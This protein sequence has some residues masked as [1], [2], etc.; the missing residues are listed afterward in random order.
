MS[1]KQRS[2]RKDRTT[3]LPAALVSEL[4][5]IDAEKDSRLKLRFNHS[6]LTRKAE[7]KQKRDEKK[8]RKAAFATH[9]SQ[10]KSPTVLPK[11]PGVGPVGNKG[12]KRKLE[13]ASPEKSS[14]VK[15]TKLASG[16]KEPRS[17]SDTGKARSTKNDKGTSNIP[18]TKNK[19]Q[20]ETVEADKR[21]LNKLAETNP[22]FVRMLRQSNLISPDML[23]QRAGGGDAFTTA[24]EDEQEIRK[25]SR[26]LGIKSE[27]QMD[28][29]LKG[30]GLGDIVQISSSTT[31]EDQKKMSKA[32]SPSDDEYAEEQIEGFGDDDDFG[33]GVDDGDEDEFD[34]VEEDDI[35]SEGDGVSHSDDNEQDD[36][37]AMES[38]EFNKNGSESVGDEDHDDGGD[39][40][41]EVTGTQSSDTPALSGKYVPPHLRKQHKSEPTIPVSS[42]ISAAAAKIAMMDDSKRKADPSY[43]RLKRQMQGLM[44]RLSDTNIENIFGNLEEIYRSNRRKDVTEIFTELILSYIGDH[45]NLLDSFVLTYAAL[46]A[47]VHNVLGLE[48][49]ASFVQEMIE[50][51]ERSRSE[52]DQSSA[53]ELP[54]KR[55]TN[56]ASLLARL[57]NFK[58]V[59]CVL[60]YD[61][62]REALSRL[63]EIDIEMLLRILR[64]CGPE[65][66]HDDPSALREI[67][68]L[69]QSEVAKRDPKLLSARC[70][71]MI[72]TINDLKNNHRQKKGAGASGK[73]NELQAEKLGKF[74]NGIVSRR[75]G[76]SEALR[77][78][79]KD[80]RSVDTKGRWWLVGAAWAGR[81][82]DDD[83]AGNN[84]NKVKKWTTEI[85]KG[86]SGDLVSLARKQKMNTEVRRNIFVSL[87]SSEDCVDAFEKVNKL[88]LNEKQERDIVRVTQ[89]KV[90]NP[91]YALVGQKFCEYAYR[92]KITFQYALWDL[93]K[94]LEE[95]DEDD[96]FGVR[97]IANA[98][99]MYAYLIAVRSLTL[100]VLKILNFAG[101]SKRQALFLQLLLSTLLLT[102]MPAVN[103]PLASSKSRKPNDFDF[104][105]DVEESR[106]RRE[107]AIAAA[108]MGAF[109]SRAL[110]ELGDEVICDAFARV[111]AAAAA[112]ETETGFGSRDGKKASG[113]SAALPSTLREG[114]VFFMYQYLW[115]D[116]HNSGQRNRSAQFWIKDDAD[117]KTIARRIKMAKK[118][119][120]EEQ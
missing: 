12:M 61:V 54:N 106:R 109:G 7:R 62:I 101:L 79:L 77:V 97:E 21:R 58:V 71:F 87:M 34:N 60:L 38:D 102:R 110:M 26:L 40:D 24:G 64:I 52:S 103:A 93:L 66:R 68:L 31:K 19:S 107:D 74:V 108:T 1:H 70:K 119:L 92:F 116:A 10:A 105:V 45:A 81:S 11:Q 113:G 55:C 91:F 43:I 44:N 100:A 47:V 6:I 63:D 56:L 65:L 32:Q 72:E 13:E 37:G 50:L 53:D 90:Y 57:Y 51:F 82:D 23:D 5:G 9:G 117:R 35:D 41:E 69:L 95:D 2:N 39:S 8:Q 94:A 46:V 98:A 118:I 73:G 14:D 99:K 112:S 86:S 75:G 120:V 96:E 83:E 15:K 115:P 49:G 111:G 3:Q 22:G 59:S 89:E 16:S 76:G 36:H 80:I 78:T 17:G 20:R 88:G 84:I 42:Q 28:A 33:L 104:D 67:V 114:L 4:E 29:F 30:S 85:E 18:P 25:Y 48:I 27:K